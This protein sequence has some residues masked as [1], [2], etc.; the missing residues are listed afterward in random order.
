MAARLAVNFI[1]I[2]QKYI[3]ILVPVCCRFSPSCSEYTK[4]AIVKYGF[5]NGM[6]KGIKRVAM[7]HPFSQKSGY[8]PLV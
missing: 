2:Y 8:D 7:C 4:Q 5:F 6:K 3:R 1:T